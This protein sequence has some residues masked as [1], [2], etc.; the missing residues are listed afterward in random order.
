VPGSAAFAAVTSGD[1]S[2]GALGTVSYVDGP[3][4]WLFGHPLDGA[5]RRSLFLQEAFVHTVINN[6]IAVEDVST[7]KLSS[8]GR[9]VGTITS[10]GPSAVV[11]RLGAPPPGFPLRVTARDVRAGREASSLTRIADEGDV[12]RP[13]G[14]SPLTLAASA[15]VAEAAGGILPGAPA[16]QTG[17]MCVTIGLRELRRPLRFCNSYA[18]DGAVPNALAGAAATDMSAAVALLDAYRFGTLHPTGVDVVL[19]AAAGLN[20]AFIT[21]ATAPRRVRR[22]RVLRVR[23]RLRHTGTGARSTRTIRIRVP[24]DT[25][26]G[27]RTLRLVGT[28]ADAGSDPEDPGEL[29]IV[30]EEPEAGGDAGPRSPEDLRAAFDALGRFDGITATFSGGEAREAFRDPRLRITGRAR[31][32]VTVRG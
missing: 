21:G 4:V 13:A 1:V 23:L 22:G 32:R 10:D 8:P 28:P 17:D 26:R 12:G 5:G 27:A 14:I 29:S 7:Y 19:R 31:L 15:A 24:R 11:G 20:Q 6:P 30:F 3:S 18:I 2:I 9:D 16:R 25:P